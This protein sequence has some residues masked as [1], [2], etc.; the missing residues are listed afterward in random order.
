MANPDAPI[1]AVAERAGVG[2]SALYRR[3]ESKEEMLRQLCSEGLDR[4]LALAEAAVADAGDPWT[5]FREFLFRA[6]DANTNALVAR[7]AGTFTPTPE[8]YAEGA[9]AH[10][11][12]TELFERAKASGA[13]RADV[14]VGDL[15]PIYEQLS[16][17]D[18][19]DEERN[20]QLR[21]RYLQLFL[22]GLRA[23][24]PDPLPGPPPTWAELESRW[25]PLT[26]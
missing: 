26:G 23:P 11:L 7:L 15:G 16:S 5:V 13:I 18:V 25:N 12:N 6:V 22:D 21:R 20:R 9:R 3:Y 2:M 19:G 17:V 1:A 14:E 8:L 24:S 4:Y 10:R